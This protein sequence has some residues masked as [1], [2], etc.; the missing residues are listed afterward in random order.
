LFACREDISLLHHRKVTDFF[1]KQWK[2]SAKN[3][4]AKEQKVS[5]TK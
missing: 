1:G 5:D 3:Y 4:V 2:T